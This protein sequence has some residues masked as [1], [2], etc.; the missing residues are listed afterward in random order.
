MHSQIKLNANQEQ[1]AYIMLHH[2]E[3][4]NDHNRATVIYNTNL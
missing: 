1:E 3:Q 2:I 4:L